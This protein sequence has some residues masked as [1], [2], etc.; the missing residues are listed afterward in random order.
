MMPFP[1]NPLEATL[2]GVRDG[3]ASADQLL[4]ALGANPLWVPL[5]AGA[6]PQGHTQLPIMVLDGRPYVAVYTSAE[7]YARGAGAQAHME[8]DGKE[9]AGLMADELGLAVNP[10]AELGLPIRA[11]GIR[12]LRGGQRKVPA[13]GRLRLGAPA[14]EPHELIAALA[15]AFATTPA[16]LEARR[17]L[18]QI[19]D[20]PPMLLIGVRADRHVGTWQ[21]D[22]VGAVAQA[23]RQSPVPYP[24]ET[25]FLDDQTDPVTEWMLEHTEPLYRRPTAA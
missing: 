9:L 22:S 16:V 1:A 8:L 7:Q 17:A 25:T 20:E 4:E 11:D 21:Q 10:G 14:D 19:G 18:A 2:A 6:D 3:T 24:V 23:V 5:P 12:V 15:G 13:G